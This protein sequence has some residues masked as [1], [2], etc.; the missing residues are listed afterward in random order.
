MDVAD[1]QR[2]LIQ[3]R[4]GDTITR[5]ETVYG[6]TQG[7]KV[8]F[9]LSIFRKMVV[10]YSLILENNTSMFRLSCPSKEQSWIKC[11]AFCFAESYLKHQRCGLHVKTSKYPSKLTLLHSNR[12]YY[13]SVFGETAVSLTASSVS[14]SHAV[15]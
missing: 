6:T 7:G 2:P 4:P 10:K 9:L 13:T 3:L 8:I 14:L 11:V 5:W 1:G 15:N 12:D